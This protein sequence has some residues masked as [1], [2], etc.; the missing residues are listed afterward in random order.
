MRGGGAYAADAADVPLPS[1]SLDIHI[2]D[3]YAPEENN[4]RGC[5]FSKEALRCMWIGWAL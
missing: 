5:A 3:L 1:R 2:I 4:I